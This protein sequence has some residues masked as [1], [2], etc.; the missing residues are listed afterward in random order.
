MKNTLKLIMALFLIIT[1]CIFPGC[2]KENGGKAMKQNG[3][4]A[5][6]DYPL[7]SQSG[8]YEAVI[9]AFDD[10]GVRSFK[11]FISDINNNDSPYEADITFRTRD[12]NYVFWADEEDILWCYSGDIG[13]YFWLK[14][15][16]TWTKKIYADNPEAIVPQALKEARP[17]K[18]K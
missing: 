14:E 16:G 1:V 9:E 15:N 17:N 10:D 2:T 18:Y 11:L 8:K 7:V 5:S 12:R 6:L 4:L 13:T 3:S